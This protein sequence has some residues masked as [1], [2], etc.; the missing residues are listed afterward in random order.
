MMTYRTRI[1]VKKLFDF[2]GG[3]AKTLDGSLNC[4]YILTLFL[5][6]L[7]LN[8]SHCTAGKQWNKSFPWT[9]VINISWLHNNAPWCRNC[10]VVDKRSKY[11][12]NVLI[13]QMLTPDKDVLSDW[14]KHNIQNNRQHL[15]CSIQNRNNICSWSRLRYCR[16]RLSWNKITQNHKGIFTKNWNPKAILLLHLIESTKST[17]PVQ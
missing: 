14:I 3:Q 11:L 12:E 7:T 2:M 5:F 6:L 16:L 15:W 10:K 13:R 4:L 17:M 1:S 9:K 8:D